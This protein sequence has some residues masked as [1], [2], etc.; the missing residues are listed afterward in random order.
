MKI[1]VIENQLWLTPEGTA[2]RTNIEKKA[3][4][5]MHKFGVSS[6]VARIYAAIAICSEYLPDIRLEP[7]KVLYQDGS[8]SIYPKGLDGASYPEVIVCP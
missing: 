4:V 2:E 6:R 5:A 7:S 8:F 3:K 1:E